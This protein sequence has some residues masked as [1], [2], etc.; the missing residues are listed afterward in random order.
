MCLDPDKDVNLFENIGDAVKEGAKKLPIKDS[1]GAI[2]GT[3]VEN[4][5]G[6]NSY[7]PTGLTGAFADMVHSKQYMT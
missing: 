5:F 3:T 2:F 7:R 1:P 4:A 6:K